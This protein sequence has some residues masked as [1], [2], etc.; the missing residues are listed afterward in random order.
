[1]FDFVGAAGLPFPSLTR[2]D[3]GLIVGAAGAGVFLWRTYQSGG[4]RQS[5][6]LPLVLLGVGAALALSTDAK[7]MPLIGPGVDSALTKL[8]IEKGPSVTS[9]YYDQPRY[10]A[11]P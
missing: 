10:T 5:V 11:R 2:R 1:M 7:T 9:G 6:V 8:G 4:A 3:A